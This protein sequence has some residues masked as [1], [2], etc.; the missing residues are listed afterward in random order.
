MDLKVAQTFA[1]LQDVKINT[2]ELV[3][4]WILITYDIPVS[5][6]GNKARFQFL[7]LAPR[8]GAVMH[9]RSV[10]LMP[11]THQAQLAGVELS[12]VVGGEVYMWSS[13]VV[14][15]MTNEDVTKFYDR[16]INEQIDHIEER[17]TQEN[18]LI[19]EKHEG[20]ADRMHRKTVNLFNQVLFSCVQRGSGASTIQRLTTIEQRLFGEPEK[21][22]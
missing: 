14:G 12:K 11:N 18:T 4:E 6:E 2:R 7:K 9:S 13:K 21:K 1:R 5:E 22:E 3:D 16:K 17:M 19:E 20:M 15:G 8:I 10:Y